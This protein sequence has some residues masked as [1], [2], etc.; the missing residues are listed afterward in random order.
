MWR[1]DTYKKNPTKNNN[2]LVGHHWYETEQQ[3][4][5]AIWAINHMPHK[6]YIYQPGEN[7]EQISVSL[8]GHHA[9]GPFEDTKF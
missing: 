6:Q 8:G 1:I 4:I 5:N 7:R 3:A 2:V 9:S